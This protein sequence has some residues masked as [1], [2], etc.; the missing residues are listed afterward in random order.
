MLDNL[1]VKMSINYRVTVNTGDVLSAGTIDKISVSLVGSLGVSDIVRI[2]SLT[3]FVQ[4]V[5]KSLYMKTKSDLGDILLV[6]LYKQKHTLLPED[7][8]YCGHITVEAPN[9]RVYYFPC[10]AWLSDSDSL[11]VIEGT[12]RK[13]HEYNSATLEEHRR[14]EMQKRQETYQWNAF[15]PRIPKSINCEKAS[16]LPRDAQIPLQR[17]IGTLLNVDSAI[18]ELGLKPMSHAV[19]GKLS[20]LRSQFDF[21]RLPVSAY[22]MKHW[23]EDTFF[24]YQY[25]NGSNPILIKQ[26]SEIPP[27][28]PVTNEM[29]SLFLGANTSLQQ[30][31]QKGNIFI[32]DYELLD[33]IAANSKPKQQYLEAPM[34]LLH[35]NPANELV[36]IAI[37]L[38]QQPGP[39][40]PIFLP[41]DSKHDWRLAKIWVRH[42]DAQIHQLVSHLLKTHLFAEIFC[43]ATLRKLPSAHPV[44]K[45]LMPHLKFTLH[46]NTEA[47][48]LLISEGGIFDQAF[49]TGGTAKLIILQ[50]ALEHTTYSSLCLP[51][52]LASR[53]VEKI[54]NYYYRDDAL[55]IWSAINKFIENIVDLYY[56]SDASVQEDA[57]IQEWATEIF[58][59]GFLARPSSGFPTSFYTKADFVKYLTMVIFTCSGQHSSV[60]G[61]Q[62]DWGSWVPNNPSTMQKPAPTEKGKV[63]KE[64]IL[65]TLP[66]KTATAS[67][68]ATIHLL[69]KPAPSSTKL[70]TY[71]EER[72]TEVTAKACIEEFQEALLKIEEEIVKRNEGLELKYTYFLPS[73]IDNSVAI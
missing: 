24:G 45:L 31:V 72:F 12:A 60:N 59:E 30:E 27:K 69:S 11:E 32:V 51:E 58:T 54:P 21:C 22:V 13:R 46:I 9:N 8:W 18:L 6:R 20:E 67:V 2:W 43:I 34:C 61:G 19:W 26:C 56:E 52:D 62:F 40:N 44:F 10:Y 41:S 7:S 17:K 55:K 70:G 66:G 28:F 16:N 39:A 1:R 29:V 47:R 50:R 37:Q 42:A 64:D 73:V 48:T 33:G 57:E 25:L 63:S 65:F 49:S 36:P 3:P 71:V 23:K 38:R 68:L 35:L 4:G 15:A 14:K 53:R 5:G